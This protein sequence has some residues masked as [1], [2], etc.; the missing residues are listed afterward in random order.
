[1]SVALSFVTIEHLASTKYKHSEW[2]RPPSAEITLK[3][4]QQ[5]QQKQLLGL[6]L[7][8]L[9]SISWTSAGIRNS[10]AT[11]INSSKYLHTSSVF[12]FGQP[13]QIDP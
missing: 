11:S 9:I 13:K 6:E 7:M 12:K 5:S 4:W 10:S 2:R 8:S 1:M 3:A